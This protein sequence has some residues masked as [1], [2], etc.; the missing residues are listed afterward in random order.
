MFSPGN[1]CGNIDN[2][3]A[4]LR[5][6]EGLFAF[7]ILFINSSRILSALTPFKLGSFLSAINVSG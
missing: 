2:A 3:C 4:N 6:L 7:L 5:Y 1:I